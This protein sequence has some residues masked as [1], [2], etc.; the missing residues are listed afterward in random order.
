MEAYSTD[1]IL[2]TFISLSLLL[3]RCEARAA[4]KQFQATLYMNNNASICHDGFMSVYIPKLQFAGLPFTIYVQGKSDSK[5]ISYPWHIALMW[6]C[7]L[8]SCLCLNVHPDERSGYYQ[9]IAVAKQCHYFL[10]ETDTVIILTVASH[11]CFVRR[12]V[13][14]KVSWACVSF[15]N[16]DMYC[17]LFPILILLY[18]FVK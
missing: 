7:F 5:N 6:L 4:S 16:A 8:C 1:F 15:F 12:Q 13:S 18:H 9:A 3:L 11:G 10:R 2:V 17:C 14:W